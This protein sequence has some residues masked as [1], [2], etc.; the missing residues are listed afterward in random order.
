MT[1]AGEQNSPIKKRNRLPTRKKILFAVLS[2]VL[3]VAATVTVAYLRYLHPTGAIMSGIYAIRNYRAGIPMVNFFLLQAGEKYIAIDAGSDSAQT[4]NELQ[5]LGISA[6]DV[7]AVFLTH[8]HYDHIGALNLFRNATVYSWDTDFLYAESSKYSPVFER[9]DITHH[10]MADGETV[11]LNGTSIQCIYTPGHTSDSVCYL[12]DEKYLFVGDLFVTGNLP[13]RYDVKL[14]IQYQEKML[15]T[16][17]VEY[18]FTGHFGLF[19]NA[20]FFRWWL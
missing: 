14:Q 2:L 7:A 1:M 9:P 5:K 17:G 4:E 20:G 12:V 16:A 13:Q 19:K 18:I 3:T 8:S 6:D 10:T 15:S 11:K